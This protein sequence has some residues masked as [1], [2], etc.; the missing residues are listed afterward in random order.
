MRWAAIGAAIA[1][2]CAYPVDPAACALDA[3]CGT[4]NSCIAGECHE[5]TRTCP[6]L[7]ARYSSI[8]RNLFKV[9]CGSKNSNCHSAEAARSTTGL[10]LAGDAWSGIVNVPALNLGRDSD[11]GTVNAGLLVE[12]GNPDASFLVTK[13]ELKTAHDPRF[14]S[15]MPADNPGI[16]SDCPQAMDPIVQWIQQGAPRN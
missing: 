6:V 2:G 5:G 12:P 1:C 4:G 15:G 16:I 9:S 14:G 7:T 10:D 3:D 11:A 8:D 13:L